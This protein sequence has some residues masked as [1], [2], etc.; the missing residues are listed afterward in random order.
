MSSVRS[1]EAGDI[2]TVADL[3]QRLL[4]KTNAP[5]SA[6]LKSY[7]GTLFLDGESLRTGLTSRVHVRGDGTVSAFL[8][9]LPVEM[10]FEGRRLLA[11]N[12]GSFVS[13]DRDPDPFAGARL[14]RE[15]L[16][17]PQDL[18][19]SE[20]ANEISTEMWRGA[21]ASVLGPYSLEWLR[22]LKPSAFAL[23]AVARRLPFARVARPL[24][25]LADA[26]VC[27]RGDKPAWF[28][29]RPLPGKADSFVDVPASDDDFIAAFLKFA[30]AFALR[31][32][33]EPPVL[34]AMLRHAKRKAFHG[35]RVQ[36]L[37]KAR[38]GAVV[39]AY[40][41]Y[42]D[43]GGV[44]RTVQLLAAPGQESVVIDC[45]IRNA[46]ERGLVAIRGRTLPPLLPA[47]VGKKCA[48]VHGAATIVHTRDPALLEAMVAGKAFIN[49]LVGE[50]WTRLIGDR[51]E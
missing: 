40:L 32:R 14:L 24:A 44:G 42:G 29:Y 6:D 27:R 35:E 8:G 11:A 45:L 28:H 43:A 50:G 19:F 26:V 30:Q 17:G 15:V 3:F 13:D 47:M 5:A 34:E 22:I 16:S 18:S 49:G 20:T 51:F 31:P 39:G 23:E 2:G 9:V 12:C 33:W 46:Y 25:R 38:S 1:F 48:F 7:L 36:H 41:Y 37:V 10:E 4:R 21:R